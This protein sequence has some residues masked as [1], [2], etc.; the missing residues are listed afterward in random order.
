MSHIAR[1][2]YDSKHK[3]LLKS[4]SLFGES[5]APLTHQSI[6]HSNPLDASCPLALLQKCFQP[7]EESNI[8]HAAGS[9][10]RKPCAAGSKASTFRLTHRN[11]GMPWKEGA[12]Q[13]SPTLCSTPYSFFLFL[14]EQRNNT[15][16]GRPW[17]PALGE[18]YLKENKWI[19]YG[20]LEGT[21]EPGNDKRWYELYSK[22]EQ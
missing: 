17:K 14:G 6:C 7:C 15:Y 4:E 13:G 8:C 21:A 12:S 22:H 16:E 9:S 20:K 5:A 2:N 18:P 10:H 1:S 3:V 11:R 19:L